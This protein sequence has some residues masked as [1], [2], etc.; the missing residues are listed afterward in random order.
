MRPGR[1]GLGGGRAEYDH[2]AVALE[3]ADGRIEEA[4]QLDQLGRVGDPGGVE[5]QRLGLA[6]CAGPFDLERVERPLELPLDAAARG[7]ARE[8]FAP[9]QG[10][11]LA[12]PLELNRLRQAELSGHGREARGVDD[13]RVA[14]AHALPPALSSVATTPCPAAAQMLITPLPFSF[15]CSCL[16]SAATIRPPV[17]AK[18]WP[19]ASEPPLTLSFWRSIEPNGPSRPS[20][21][22]QNSESSQAFSVQSTWAAK[23]SWISK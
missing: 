10:A 6:L 15:S 18:G 3:A 16:A 4:L 23:A 11:A 20:R 21:S 5:D 8:H 9:D 17:A 22:L 7:A 2:A 1:A 14:V 19:A 12:S 13:C